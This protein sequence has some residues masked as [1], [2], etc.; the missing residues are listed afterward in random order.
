MKELETFEFKLLEAQVEMMHRQWKIERLRALVLG[1]ELSPLD[2][3][4]GPRFNN[5]DD[6]ME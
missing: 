1:L 2:D 6:E 5:Y 3:M 4:Y